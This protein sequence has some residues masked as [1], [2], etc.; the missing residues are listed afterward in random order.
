M[1]YNTCPNV[2]KNGRK[3]RAS[4]KSGFKQCT[5][6]LG[7]DTID[8]TECGDD[9]YAIAPVATADERNLKIQIVKNSPG[10]VFICQIIFMT[11]MFIAEYNFIKQSNLRQLE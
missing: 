4:L 8:L 6:H 5:R 11:L 2:C 10:Y 7:L 3:C 1:A 9:E